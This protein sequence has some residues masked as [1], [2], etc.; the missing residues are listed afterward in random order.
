MWLWEIYN[1]VKIKRFDKKYHLHGDKI[2]IDCCFKL[3]EL[4]ISSIS[5]V[6][7]LKVLYLIT[8]YIYR[9]D[10]SYAT[11]TAAGANDFLEVRTKTIN[12]KINGVVCINGWI[13]SSSMK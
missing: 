7:K 8:F 5:F 2:K 1:F 13:V 4:V 12:A 11:P 3:F 6:S 9:F 10:L